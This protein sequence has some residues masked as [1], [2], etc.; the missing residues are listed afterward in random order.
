[1]FPDRKTALQELAK[2][3]ELNPGPWGQH[4]RNVAHA[5]ELIAGRCDKM[6]SDKAFVCGLL[7]DIGRKFGV[8]HMRH[9]SDGYSYMMSLGYDEAARIC[10]THSFAG[11]TIDGYVGRLDVN[12]QELAMIKTELSRADMD[13]YDDLIQLC[14][15]LAGSDGVMDIEARMADVRRRYG[16]YPKA[17]WDMNM[18]LKARFEAAMGRDVYEVVDKE[19]YRPQHAQ[20]QE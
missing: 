18:V 4:S 5:A 2:A 15:A 9:V 17:K 8:S 20:G 1:M 7:H 16:S 19:G 3:E 12:D 10:L 14:D 13:E 6:D 11:R